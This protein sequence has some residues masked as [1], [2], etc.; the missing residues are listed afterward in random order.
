MVGCVWG[1]REYGWKKGS[2]SKKTMNGIY[3]ETRDGGQRRRDTRGSILPYRQTG[4]NVVIQHHGDIVHHCQIL[5]KINKV[6]QLRI[7]WITKP[8]RHRDSIRRVEYITCWW[9]IEDQGLGKLASKLRKV[10]YNGIH[11]QYRYQATTITPPP[12]TLT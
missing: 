9:I 1:G 4:I 11:H 5:K 2:K 12:F 10:L 6:T 7:M 8:C 3:I